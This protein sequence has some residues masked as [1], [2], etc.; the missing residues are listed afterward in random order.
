MTMFFKNLEG[1]WPLSPLATPMPAVYVDCGYTL[2]TFS[3]T[4]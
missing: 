1:L 3:Q 4:Y 2:W